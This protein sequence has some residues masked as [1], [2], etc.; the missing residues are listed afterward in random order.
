ML[1]SMKF[2]ALLPAVLCVL[3]VML[4]PLVLTSC[5]GNGEAAGSHDDA[6]YTPGGRNEGVV[7]TLIP[8]T[9]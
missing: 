8:V 2:P 3:S 4:C 6:T 9:K 5:P 7:L 1:K